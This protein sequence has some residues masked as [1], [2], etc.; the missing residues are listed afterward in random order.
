MNTAHYNL[1]KIIKIRVCDFHE[2]NWHCY[3]P[4]RKFFG[5]IVRPAGVYSVIG[6]SFICRVDEMKE[7]MATYVFRDNDVFHKPECILFFEDGHQVSHPCETIDEAMKKA[8][9]IK[10]QCGKWI[11]IE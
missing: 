8:E 5:M 2:D 9:E 11:S 6:G 3:K 7:K 10:A 1:N 4:E